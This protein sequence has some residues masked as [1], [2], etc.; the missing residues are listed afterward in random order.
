MPACRRKWARI[1]GDNLRNDTPLTS[2]PADKLFIAVGAKVPML[3]LSFG[4]S[5]EHAWAQ[6]RVED[7]TLAV[8]D[9]N[10]VGI[11]AGWAPA[12]GVL[13]GFRVDAGI[14]NHIDKQ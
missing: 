10:V 14:D 1:G 5:N 13:K 12:A 11:F 9:Y 4:V 7:Q 8:D 3:D 2:I 6:H